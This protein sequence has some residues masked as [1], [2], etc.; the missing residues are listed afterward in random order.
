MTPERWNQ[1]EG[2][3]LRAVEVPPDDRLKFLDEECTGDEA[4]R[5]E[6]N[7]LLACD[8]PGAPLMDR[9]LPS[10]SDLQADMAG[11]RIGVYRLVRLLGHGGMGSVHLAVRDDEQF[12]MEVAVKLLKRGMD[13]DFM[14]SR[15]RQER[16]ILA[17]LDHPFIARLL[18][19]GATE[20]GL[21]FF[22]LEYVDGLP[23]SK[24]C[25]GKRLNLTERLRLFRLVC[26][27]VQ[28]AHQNLVVHRDL[29]PGNILITKEGIPKLLDFGIAK[30]I[31]PVDGSR[32]RLAT[33][34]RR[35]LRMMTP[36]YASPEQAMGLTVS[37]ATD[38]Y[39]LGAVLYELLSGKRPHRFTTESPTDMEKAICEVEPEKPSV[40]AADRRLAG[41]LDNIILTAMRKAPERRYTS[42]A[43]FSEDIRRHMEGLPVAA[44]EDRWTYRAGKFIG[45]HRVGVATALLVLASLVAGIVTT[46][47]QARRA[48]RRFQLI[49]GLSNSMLF[50][51]NDQL[52]R[53]PGSTES[54]ASLVHTVLNYLD[55]LARDTGS[56]PSLDL[57]IANA[58]RRVAGLEGHPFRMNLG[59]MPAALNH[60][61]K[62]LEIYERLANR[63]DTRKRVIPALIGA[64]I[65]AGDIEARTG[66]AEAAMARLHKAMAIAAEASARDSS[67]VPPDSWI[68]LY[69]RLGDA[70]SRRGAADAALPH[71]RKALEISQKSTVSNHSLNAR[72]TLRGAYVRLAGAQLASGDLYGARDSYQTAL[73][74]IQ[75]LLR[76][77]DAT[78]EI[79]YG[80]IPVHHSLGD[81]LGGPDE[82]NLGDRAGAL[83]HYRAAV[84][85]AERL[86][87]AD[88]HEVRSRDDLQASYR[89]AGAILLNDRPAEALDYYRKAFAVT[90]NL[91]EASFTNINYRRDLA[92]GRLAI[93]EALHRLGKKDEALDYMTRALEAMRE[94]IAAAPHQIF[95]IETL[96]RAHADIG[97]LLLDRGDAA[98]ALEN[99]LQGLAATEKLIRNTP[100]SLH[101][102]RDRA[103][104]YESLGRYYATLAARPGTTAASRLEMKTQARSWFQ[105]SLAVWQEW[106]HRKVAVPYAARREDQASAFLAD[107]KLP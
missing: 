38:V 88:Q 95:W 17:N 50:D 106:T 99:L 78:M 6:V 90:Q 27:A 41:D 84:D 18:D 10:V 96:A 24:Y 71:Y 105:K 98:G 91:R 83:A 43:E 86:A 7:S 74:S 40:A 81:I 47:N 2:L 77:P 89:R 33:L 59:Q 101:F 30:L 70:E 75:E 80:L 72:S 58:Y 12:Q 32:S 82:L 104:A 97:A 55:T 87:A 42:V 46:T 37:T 56:D 51:F 67:A 79:Q 21:P 1:I 39:S 49:R 4:L 52:E 11:R 100:S 8:N 20:D 45:R 85:I 48:E 68:Y 73:Q 5:R 35:D 60:Y 25:T 54:R 103:D 92:S 63:S 66:N 57:E 23:I 53:L 76:E 62:A 28:H 22:V 26:E 65:E 3:F 61:R 102:Q 31:D 19:G 69:F 64:N 9:S 34:T 107:L 44:H 94:V 15:F 36:D 14:L 29:K 16:Q 93:G 13:T